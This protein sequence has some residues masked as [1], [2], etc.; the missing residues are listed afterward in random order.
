M[1]RNR[2]QRIVIIEGVIK[3]ASCFG[4]I[5]IKLLMNLKMVK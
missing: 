3:T 4:L 5:G 1:R 2:L